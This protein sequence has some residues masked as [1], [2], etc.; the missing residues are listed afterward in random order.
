[1]LRQTYPYGPKKKHSGAFGGRSGPSSHWGATADQSPYNK[2]KVI[3]VIRN[4]TKPRTNVKIL[5]NRRSVQSFEQLM[6]D[7]ADAFGPKWKNNK[8]RKLFTIKGKEVQGIADFF[9]DDEVYIGLGNEPLTTGD[10]QD[11]LDEVYPES[12]YPRTLMREWDKTKR[13]YAQGARKVELVKKDGY[14]D[15]SKI[16][17]GLGSDASKDGEDQNNEV[18]YQP[19]PADDNKKRRKRPSDKDKMAPLSSVPVPEEDLVVRLEQERLKAIEEEKE[20]TRKRMQKRLDSE[21]KALDDEKRKRGLIPQKQSAND[22]FK[23][24]DEKKERDLEKEKERER[25][26]QQELEHQKEAAEQ[27]KKQAEERDKAKKEIEAQREKEIAEKAQKDKETRRNK[28]KERQTPRGVKEP[29]LPAVK[30]QNED[31]KKKKVDDSDGRSSKASKSKDKVKDDESKKATGKDSPRKPAEDKK[32]LEKPLDKDATKGEDVKPANQNDKNHAD[33]IFNI[34]KE[35]VNV[36]RSDP[37]DKVNKDKISKDSQDKETEK[38]KEA[39]KNEPDKD[40]KLKK[41]RSKTIIHKTKME[42]QISNAEHVLDKYEPG[43]V[44]GDGNFAIVKS[45]KLKNTNKEFAMKIIDKSKLKGKEHM[46]ENEIALMKICNQPNI[47][48]L[49][50]EFETKAEIYLIMELVKVR[51]LHFSTIDQSKHGASGVVSATN[52]LCYLPFPF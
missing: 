44:L 42:R 11:I 22:P 34:P 32:N 9:R 19:S 36:P 21:K 40:D 23:Q 25:Q 26:R 39:K 49:Y 30:T 12:H 29:E 2:P 4:G 5:L 37:V 46:I 13:R 43:K 45:A 47:V 24:I 48:K 51:G 41:R 28:S 15:D 31:P 20:K 6:K 3:T 7:I 33:D 16:D 27:A 38:E 1:M 8:V 17:S 52:N 35:D 50:E 10:V 14:N 18:I